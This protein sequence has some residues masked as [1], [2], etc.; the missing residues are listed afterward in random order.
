MLNTYPGVA[1]ALSMGVPGP[2]G[3]TVLVSYVTPVKGGTLFPDD[4]IDFA[5]QSLPSHMVPQSVVVV[6]QEFELTP[7]GEIDRKKL[8]TAGDFTRVTDF[9]APRTQLQRHRRRVRAD[10]RARADQRP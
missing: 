9:V 2:A 10:A 6:D 7:V 5:A 3:A 1:N 8:P 4:V